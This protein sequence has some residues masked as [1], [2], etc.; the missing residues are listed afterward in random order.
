M[1]AI[2]I[3]AGFIFAA[4]LGGC[5]TQPRPSLQTRLPDLTS[6]VLMRT[7][8]GA[9]APQAMSVDQTAGV[10]VTYDVIFI[11]ESHRHPGNHLAEMEL[12]RA[13]HARAP[14]LSLTMEQFE[15]DVQP[16][17]DDYLAGKIGE[18]PFM[19]KS[20]AWN[21]YTT[22]YRPLI[23]YAKEHKLPVIAANAPEDVVRC[24]GKEGE[25][26]FARMKP[27]QRGWAAAELHTQDGPYKD[28]FM[29]FVSHDA[30][31]GG[32]SDKDKPKEKKPPS[33]SAIRSFAAQV[34]RDDT[35][36]ESIARHMQ[37]NPG[38]K[39]VQINGSF[40]SDSFLGTVERLKMRMPQLKIAVVSPAQPEDPARPQVSDD[41]AKA[42]T[43]VLLLRGLPESYANDDEMKAAIAK[44]VETRAKT[45]CE[46]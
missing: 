22:S 41:D 44:Q 5:A 25:A 17:V 12:F 42:G 36:A 24:V 13:I 46:M 18:A 45:K 30:G 8:A 32:D 35:M 37:N 6:F 27:E 16:V 19:E 15:R 38:R 43:F 34:T 23:E 20:R 1:L 21:N 33:E 39:V 9:H 2:R 10:L 14:A 11:G 40:H 29:G 4:A 26:F 3:C 7:D 31:H 28:K